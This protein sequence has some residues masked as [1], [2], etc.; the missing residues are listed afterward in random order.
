MA[1]IVG[2]VLGGVTVRTKL[3]LVLSA[4]SLTLMVIVAVP[5]SF[6]AGTSVTARLESMPPRV[7]LAS[8]N[9]VWSDEPVVTTRLLAAVSKSPITNAMGPAVEFTGIVRLAMAEMV[10]RSFTGLTVSRKL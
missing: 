5:T 3:R 8:G 7:M 10:G 6:A 1:P 9:N 2:G 4:P